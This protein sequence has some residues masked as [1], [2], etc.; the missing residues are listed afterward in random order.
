MTNADKIRNMTDEELRDFI[1]G[2]TSCIHCGF[3]SYGGCDLERWLAA[4]HDKEDDDND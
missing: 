1:C 4:E 3:N 2:N